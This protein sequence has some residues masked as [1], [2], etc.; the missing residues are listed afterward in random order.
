MTTST[1]RSSLRTTAPTSRH[2]GGDGRSTSR[3]WLEGS[4]TR[5]QY[6]DLLTS[7]PLIPYFQRRGVPSDNIPLVFSRGPPPPGCP[8]R[9]T[10]RILDSLTFQ[11]DRIND[12]SVR[13]REPGLPKYDSGGSSSSNLKRISA[14]A[15]V[16]NSSRVSSTCINIS[17]SKRVRAGIQH[18]GW[19]KPQRPLNQL[20]RLLPNSKRHTLLNNARGP[21]I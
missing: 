12:S 3:S 13:R 10:T 9:R 21:S 5:P 8:S 15:S 17:K 18:V 6:L 16:S 19:I 4:R 2:P 14:E 1:L 7:A 20:I 11:N